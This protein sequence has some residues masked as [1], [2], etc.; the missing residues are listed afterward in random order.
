MT[1]LNKD[2]IG[3]GLKLQVVRGIDFYLLNGK[4]TLLYPQEFI[5]DPCGMA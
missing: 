2:L 1:F 4:A 5:Y 3:H